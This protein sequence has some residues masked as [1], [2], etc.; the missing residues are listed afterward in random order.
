MAWFSP[1]KTSG[2]T[3]RS[4]SSVIIRITWGLGHLPMDYIAMGQHDLLFISIF[5]LTGSFFLT[6]PAMA[7]AEWL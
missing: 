3:H 6:A 2:K 5:I 1:P 7:R 4:D